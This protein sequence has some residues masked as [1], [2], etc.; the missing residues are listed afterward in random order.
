MMTSAIWWWYRRIK[1]STTANPYFIFIPYFV[2]N[3]PNSKSNGHIIAEWRL[4]GY[5][6]IMFFL[7]AGQACKY[8]KWWHHRW[9]PETNPGIDLDNHFALSG[10]CFHLK[11]VKTVCS[12]VTA[13][14]LQI[15]EVQLLAFW[16]CCLELHVKIIRRREHGGVTVVGYVGPFGTRTAVRSA[17]PA[18]TPHQQQRQTAVEC[19]PN[20]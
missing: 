1:H 11:M 15:Y 2:I 18:S 10:E 3:T 6:L 7:P 17:L 5:V 12:D 14:C 9:Q 19:F 4:C 8:Q 20:M 13:Q 16:H